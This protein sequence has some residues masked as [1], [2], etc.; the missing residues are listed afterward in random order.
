MPNN[1]LAG[2]CMFAGSFISDSKKNKEKEERPSRDGEMRIQLDRQMDLRRL[3]F[4]GV[5]ARCGAK[6]NQA[7][8]A[9]KQAGSLAPRKSPLGCPVM[10]LKRH[11]C[12]TGAIIDM[13]IFLSEN[14]L[15]ARSARA[16]GG[17]RQSR[18]AYGTPENGAECAQK[19]VYGCQSAR[20]NRVSSGHFFIFH[21]RAGRPSGR[22]SA[23]QRSRGVAMVADERP[24]VAGAL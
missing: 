21:P 6:A 11:K 23:S 22:T 20:P 19:H 14:V 1:V 13:R 15:V 9:P 10:A 7:R 2:A 4:H 5:S 18:P 17:L 16:M 8:L 3:E 24:G 12:D